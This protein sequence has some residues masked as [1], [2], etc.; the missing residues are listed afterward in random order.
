MWIGGDYSIT[1]KW[2][3]RGYYKAFTGNANTVITISVKYKNFVDVE[4]TKT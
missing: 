4:G 1:N 2:Q 3:W